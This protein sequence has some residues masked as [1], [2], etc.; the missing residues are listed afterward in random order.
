M[1]DGRFRAMDVEKIIRNTMER[2]KDKLVWN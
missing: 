2:K 1:E